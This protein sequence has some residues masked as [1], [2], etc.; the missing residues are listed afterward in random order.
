MQ[1]PKAHKLR[2][3]ALADGICAYYM[4]KMRTLRKFEAFL[5]FVIFIPDCHPIINPEK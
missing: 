3:A 2:T 5:H 1:P 4:W